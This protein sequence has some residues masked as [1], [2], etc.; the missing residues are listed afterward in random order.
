MLIH[1]LL[2]SFKSLLQAD[3]TTVTGNVLLVGDLATLEIKL[4]ALNK[5]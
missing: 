2:V 5:N 4:L 3:P 1:P